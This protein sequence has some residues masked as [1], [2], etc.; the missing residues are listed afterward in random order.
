M[1]VAPMTMR[2]GEAFGQLAAAAARLRERH[3]EATEVSAGMSG[4]LA[5]AIRCGST[6]VRVGTGLLGGR[7]LASA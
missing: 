5:D 2:P 3:P 6:C 1:A 7:R 4:D